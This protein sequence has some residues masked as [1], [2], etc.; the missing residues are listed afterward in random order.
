MKRATVLGLIGGRSNYVRRHYLIESYVKRGQTSQ[1]KVFSPNYFVIGFECEIR[2]AAGDCLESELP[3]DT[4]ERRSET[5]MA[6]PAKRQMP[7]VHA[8]KVEP[9]GIGKP[10]RVAIA[11]GHHRD[12]SL[13]FADQFAADFCILMTNSRCVLTRTFM[14]QQ[15]FDGRWNE[16]KI[17]AQT[18]HL[19][20]MAQQTQDSIA[21][22]I[23]S[24]LLAANHR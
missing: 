16:R 5:K 13:A 21:D 19:I 14:S 11:R 22:Q 15:L 20:R 17:V 3:F 7:V 10:F 8:R 6:G 2:R 23:C 1:T 4:R 18:L 24:C 9:I 12:H